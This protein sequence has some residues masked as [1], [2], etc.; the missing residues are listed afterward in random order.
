MQKL[1]AT[2]LCKLLILVL[3]ATFEA[4]NSENTKHPSPGVLPQNCTDA[5]MFNVEFC[6]RG[7]ESGLSHAPLMARVTC[8]HQATK[9]RCYTAFPPQAPPR[10][11]PRG[12]TGTTGPH[13]PHAMC[14]TLRAQG[15]ELHT[16][17]QHAPHSP[18]GPH[19]PRGPTG[20]TGLAGPGPP[21][22]RAPPGPMRAPRAHGPHGPDWPRRPSGPTGPTGPH[23]PHGPHW[24]YE[25]VSTI[26]DTFF[27]SIH[28]ACVWSWD[29]VW[30]GPCLHPL[31]KI[32]PVGVIEVFFSDVGA[33]RPRLGTLQAWYSYC[34]TEKRQSTL[35]TQQQ[36]NN[37]VHPGYILSTH[38]RDSN[39]KSRIGRFLYDTGDLRSGDEQDALGG[40]RCGR[41]LNGV[42]DGCRLSFPSC[43][44][45]F[46]CNGAR[47]LSKDGR[48]VPSLEFQRARCPMARANAP[49]RVQS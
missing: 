21:A 6:S 47:R 7:S 46:P 19:R 27:L 16:H 39:L 24:P 13:R 32:D 30:P 10:T 2:M 36:Y 31:K 5:H 3:V 45:S 28:E 23:R 40:Q 4:T 25:K 33:L 20:P 44:S 41:R 17:G 42:V 26:P 29:P 1:R 15:C 43:A 8:R 35:R 37:A 34:S 22:S 18:H 48:V 14:P 49:T 11:L 12:T 9:S 38:N